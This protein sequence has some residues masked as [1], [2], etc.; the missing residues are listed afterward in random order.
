[1]DTMKLNGGYAMIDLTGFDMSGSKVT[2][3]G[4]YNK[5]DKAVASNKPIQAYNIAG[6]SPAEVV[7]SKGD[8]GITVTS[9]VGSFIVDSSD[10]VTPSDSSKST[11]K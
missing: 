4:I 7:A 2:L 10:G 11:K 1:M 8:N 3:T 9:V 5:L 6:H